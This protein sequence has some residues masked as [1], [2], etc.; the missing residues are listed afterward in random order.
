VAGRWRTPRCTASYFGRRGL[1]EPVAAAELDV[2]LRPLLDA[3]TRC[4]EEGVLR[5]VDPRRAAI[6]IWASVHGLVSLEIAGYLDDES[7]VLE[8]HL[9]ASAVYWLRARAS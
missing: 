4:I 7:D 1:R 3:V 9:V 5:P 2:A 6:S 8:Q